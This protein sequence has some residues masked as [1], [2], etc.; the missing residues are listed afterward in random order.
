M[1]CF[2]QLYAAVAMFNA[3]NQEVPMLITLNNLIVP[4]EEA[5]SDVTRQWPKCAEES[6]M[7][8]QGQ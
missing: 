8:Q 5:A 7:Q 3:K 2:S 6:P 4:R 1:Y